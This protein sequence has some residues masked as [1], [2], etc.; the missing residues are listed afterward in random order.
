VA[1]LLQVR[2]V[3][4]RT[5][6]GWQ[7]PHDLDAPVV[8]I[9]G[10]ADTGKSSL[11]DSA[12]FAMGRD[13]EGFRGVVDKHLREVEVGI[14]TRTGSYALRRSRRNAS[15]VEVVDG[16][17]TRLGRFPVK[18]AGDSAQT[19][20]SWLLEQVD[21]DDAFSAVRLP[22]GRTLDFPTALLPYC[23]LNQW[24]IDRHI[25]QSPRMDSTRYRVL[26]L[27]LN[28]TTVDYERLSAEI[29]DVDADIVRRRRRAT[30]I[31]LFLDGSAATHR[32]AL[33]EEIRVLRGQEAEAKAWL[34][35]LQGR[36]GTA[37]GSAERERS[38]ARAAHEEVGEA[39]SALNSARRRHR[40]AQDK[41]DEWE[42]ALQE[43]ASQEEAAARIAVG[44]HTPEMFCGNCG[45]CLH[46][47]TPAPGQ[48]Y[49]CRGPLPAHR[50]EAEQA[51]IEG[52][53]AL[54]R[55]EA[56]QWEAKVLE[57]E[58]RAQRAF[59]DLR[60]ATANF[61]NATWD[62]VTPY[63]YAITQAAAELARMRQELASLDR[64][65]DA[66]SRLREQFDQIAGMEKDQAER[67]QRLSLDATKV[68][69]LEEV[70]DHLNGIFRTIIAG[71]DLPNS[72]GKARIDSRTLLPL[73]D[74]QEF[75][76]RGGG[77]RAAVSIAYSLALLTFAR[78]RADARLPAFL[79]VDSP[80]KNLGSNK[81]D[82]GL[83][84]RVYERFIDYMGEL[85]ADQR[86]GRPFQ[87]I[88]VDNDIPTDIARRMKVVRFDR[89]NGFIRDLESLPVGDLVQMSMDDL[90][91]I[92]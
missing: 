31:E 74:E 18:D 37:T 82:K 23:Y 72:T 10:P 53:L 64:I 59:D 48:C 51:R 46:D 85:D 6:Q 44:P 45:S 49:V 22:G 92:Q 12:A 26:R 4:V 42:A 28:L 75:R 5:A 73:V 3:R 17:G 67:R 77:A 27:A 43:I 89:D 91:N 81:D 80:Q 65:Q 16:S 68:T 88:I 90:D 19:I 25:I 29:K 13:A 76:K 84:R 57:A 33:E 50:R 56:G 38:Q 8:A 78:E 47:R 70:I 30:E 79:M 9:I 69:P 2:Y 34:A 24:D 1:A 41:A 58:Q 36:V 40:A 55:E 87:V 52:N 71:I 39:E 32:E 83:S 11:L 14:R 21:L 35:Q 15:A 66:H 60:T 61:D 20:S 86:F 54:A 62:G 63:V 7:E